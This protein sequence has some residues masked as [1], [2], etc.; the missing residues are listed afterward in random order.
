MSDALVAT[1]L[2]DLAIVVVAARAAGALARRVGQ[3]A[4]IGEIAAGIVLGPSLLGALPG[5]PSAF[6]FP[7]DARPYLALAGQLGLVLFMFQVGLD[8]DRQPLKR[9][10][11][12]TAIAVGSVTVPFAAGALLLA[13][14]LWSRYAPA[15]FDRLTFALFIGTV[16]AITAFPV[17]ARI[18]RERSLDG[19]RLGSLAL[20]AAA[21]ND[22]AGWLILAAV[23][24]TLS[25]EQSLPVGAALAGTAAFVVVLLT[26]VRP[27]ILRPLQQRFVRVGEL[28][29]GV[30]AAAIGVVLAAAAASGATGTHVLFGAFLVGAA[31]PSTQRDR[32]A[33][34]VRRRL[35]PVVRVVLMPAFFVLPGF[36]MDLGRI[37][38]DGLGA[39]GL[40]LLAAIAGKGI[41]AIAGARVGRLGW[42]DSLAIGTLMNARG[43]MEL[44]VLNVGLSVGVL[45]PELYT[46]LVLMTVVTTVM[47]DPLLRRLLRRPSH[48]GAQHVW[49]GALSSSETTIGG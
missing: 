48:A 25:A 27:R 6:L 39:F 29:G 41:G 47:A 35:D 49:P 37:D 45:E 34:A 24:A 38:G 28:T 44:V 26:V 8:L 15:G 32:F 4:V 14:V 33:A 30:L 43:L 3:P 22:F 31:W 13:P 16:L 1:V 12:V 10:R 11:T 21:V 7:P 42:R 20:A 5:D 19:T 18:L 36:S 46:L 2:L 17:L 9:A 23:L 40:I